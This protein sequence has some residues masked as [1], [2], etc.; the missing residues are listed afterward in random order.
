[1][2]LVFDVGNSETTI[3]LFNDAVLRGQWRIMTGV[4]RTPDELGVLIRSLLEQGGF[5]PDQVDGAV[6]GSVVPRVTVPIAEACTRYL[7]V[8]A[9]VIV[10]G[11]SPLPIRLQV[12]EPMTVGADRI[13]NTLA[14]S[15]LFAKDCIVVDLGTATTFDCITADG[16]FLGGA[17]APGVGM[18]A[19]AL[20]SKTAKLPAT[21]LR[22]PPRAIG[23]RTEEC[24]RAGVIFG[25]ADAIDGMIRRIRK[26]WPRKTPPMVIATGGFATVLGDLCEELDRI[27]PFLTLQGLQ[28]AH[29]ILST[30]SPPALTGLS[31]QQG[32]PAS[33]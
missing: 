11:S 30:T 9:A 6:I 33:K 31:R 7:P 28:I 32:T 21:D 18:S 24:I 15:R 22:V 14:A 8:S 10:D 12:D 27:E 2:I 26:E 20:T 5:D 25:A 3:G 23:T 16:V 4:S 1:M 29:S 17:I 13:I 19:E